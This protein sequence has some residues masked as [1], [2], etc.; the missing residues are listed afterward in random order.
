MK[1]YRWLRT[2]LM[3]GVAVL[4]LGIGLNSQ[5]ANVNAKSL[6]LQYAKSATALNVNTNKIVWSKA[7]NTA[8]PIASVSKLMTPVFT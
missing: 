6:S 4:G 7:G 1:L 3:A 5:M 8:R 2:T